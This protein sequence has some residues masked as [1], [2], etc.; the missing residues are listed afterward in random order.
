MNKFKRPYYHND[1]MIVMIETSN[2]KL[3]SFLFGNKR[4]VILNISKIYQENIFSITYKK[5]DK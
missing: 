1:P 4:I 3:I 2:K 5:L